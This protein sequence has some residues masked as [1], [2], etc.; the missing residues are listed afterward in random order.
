MERGLKGT[1]GAKGQG[2][3]ADYGQRAKKGKEPKRGMEVEGQ[4]RGQMDET[5]AEQV[6]QK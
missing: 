5:R 3:G 1:G 4:I 2:K 6:H